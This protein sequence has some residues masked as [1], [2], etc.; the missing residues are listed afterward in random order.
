LRT[1]GQDRGANSTV[2]RLIRTEMEVEGRYEDVWI[3]VDEDALDQWPEGPLTTVGQEVPRV[4]GLDRARGQILY[5]A[6][7]QLPG[8]LHTAVLRSPFA[9]ARVTSIDLAAAHA[10]RGGRA[11]PGPRELEVLREAAGYVGQAVAGVCAETFGQAQAALEQ[12]NVEWEALEPLLDLDEAV[13]QESFVSDVK[14]Y[15]RGDFERG[16]AD[17]D[18]VVEAEY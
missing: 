9:R 8:M 7:I 17:G 6:D 14:T 16:V 1:L 2:A 15:E 4:D 18:V 5:T 11:V 13:R 3:V 10:A 12:L